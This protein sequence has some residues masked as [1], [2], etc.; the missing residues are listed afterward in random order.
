MDLGANEWVTFWKVT[1]PLILPGIVAAA[2]LAFSLS[3]D[4]FIITS[5]VSG[6]QN[7]FPIWV[8]SIIRNALPVQINV[9]GS[10]IFL[11]AVGYVGI[12][13]IRSARAARA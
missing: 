2:L 6:T 12:T 11:I 13:T 4:D 3:I 1:L 8:Y 5:F 9:I 7:T 10:M